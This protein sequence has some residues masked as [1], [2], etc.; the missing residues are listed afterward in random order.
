MSEKKKLIILS[1]VV[2]ALVG[3]IMAKVIMTRRQEVTIE[4]INQ[5]NDAIYGIGIEY[6]FGKVE[7]SNGVQNLSGTVWHDSFRNFGSYEPEP[8]DVGCQKK[9]NNNTR[10][11]PEKVSQNIRAQFE[12]VYG[13]NDNG[14]LTM[15]CLGFVDMPVE[16]GKTTVMVLT[17]NMTD[18]YYV[19]FQ[20]LK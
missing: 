19:R 3:G 18:G 14:R 17:G 15:S 2:L 4:V 5:A 11:Y 1:C 8:S 13:K 10:L 6:S 7:T 9:P 20:E 16:T 12:V